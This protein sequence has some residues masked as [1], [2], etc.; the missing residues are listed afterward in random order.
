MARLRAA[1]LLACCAAVALPAPRLLAQTM[2]TVSIT[3][4]LRDQTSLNAQ[5]EFAA[6][7]LRLSPGPATSLYRLQLDYDADRFVPLSRYE[8]ATGAVVLGLDRTG[9]AG[10]RVSREEHLRQSAIVEFPTTVDLGLDLNLGAVDAD[11]ELGGLRLTSVR[12]T[13]AGSRTVA[14]FSTPNPRSCTS[15]RLSAGAADVA[16]TQL[17]NSRCRH[18]AFDGGVGAVNLDF[19]GD[20]ADDAE[21]SVNLTMGQ[22]TLTLPRSVGFALTLERFLSSFQPEGF[23]RVGKTFRS[24]NYPTAEHRVSIDVTCSVAGVAVKWAD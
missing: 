19:T 8:P 2:R 9:S 22:L 24:A 1:L 4:Q 3:K 14:R 11:L 7:D 17:G 20:W 5:V 13:T 12:M 23:S 18:I 16:V 15:L 6:G 10:L 21:V